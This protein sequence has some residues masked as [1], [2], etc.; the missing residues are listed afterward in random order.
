MRHFIY[1]INTCV[2]FQDINLSYFKINYVYANYKNI[3]F[4]QLLNFLVVSSLENILLFFDSIS[5]CF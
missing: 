1:L 5:K 2:Y 3:H 4:N